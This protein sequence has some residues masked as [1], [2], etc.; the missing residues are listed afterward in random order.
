MTILDEFIKNMIRC[1][2]INE[3]IARDPLTVESAQIYQTVYER[4]QARF[5]GA[6]ESFA[7][8]IVDGI[9][10]SIKFP[11]LTV[12]AEGPFCKWLNPRIEIINKVIW[13]ATPKDESQHHE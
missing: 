3:A 1:G 13:E 10:L 8:L 5:N 12:D 11:T 7:P 6:S 9:P 4:L 2:Q